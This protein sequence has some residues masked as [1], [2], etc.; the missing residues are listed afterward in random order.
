MEYASL[1]GQIAA[2]SRWSR[3]NADERTAATSAGRL[4]AEK[5]FEKIVDPDGVLSHEERA[6]QASNARKAHFQ[7]MALASARARRRRG[8]MDRK[9]STRP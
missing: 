1:C 2:N 3:V 9:G 4:A 5:R 8:A 6:R 7:R